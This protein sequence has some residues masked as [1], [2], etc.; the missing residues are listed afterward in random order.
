MGSQETGSVQDLGGPP[1]QEGQ[2]PQLEEQPQ[3]AELRGSGAVCPSSGYS[4]PYQQPP[5][6]TPGLMNSFSG[7]NPEFTSSGN[8]H[9]K[10]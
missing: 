3:V 10:F 6:P 2:Q 1:C 4:R 5:N 8:L 7:R 9:I